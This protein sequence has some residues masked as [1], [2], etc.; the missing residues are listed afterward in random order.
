MRLNT[1]DVL[2]PAA[3][4]GP[5]FIPE[6]DALLLT[7]RPH[8]G[9]SSLQRGDFI[10]IIGPSGAGKTLLSAFVLMTTL[11]PP[12]LILP[13]ATPLPVP[14]GGRGVR[15][16]ILTPPSHASLIPA[17]VKSM[18]GHIASRLDAALREADIPIQDIQ[19][20]EVSRAI[21]DTVDAALGRLLVLRPKPRAQSWLQALRRLLG[22]R[23]QV[24]VVVCDG[25]ADG[26]WPER[27]AD[28]TKRPAMAKANM[29]DV[30]EA[31]SQLRSETGAVVIVTVQGLQP[32]APLYKTHL[33]PPYPA[34]F[35]R[36]DQ[37]PWPLNIQLTLTGPSR[38]LQFPA[39]TTL[40]EALRAQTRSDVQVCDAIVRVPGGQGLVGSPTGARWSFGIG[41]D[42]FIPFS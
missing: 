7:A 16:A 41:E 4:P 27:L 5:T 13:L 1:L 37:S 24:E 29:K 17:V 11:L 19:S 40:V 28:E 30:W 23:N 35:E 14:L 2:T 34:P 32:A 8:V 31:V 20:P 21:Q 38:S 6:L 10:E 18:R 26:Y 36:P 42:G 39:E 15:G 33:P 22:A 9:G 25:F 3:P 12:N